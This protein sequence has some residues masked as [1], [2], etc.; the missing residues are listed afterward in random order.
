M[1][2]QTLLLYTVS[3]SHELT[4]LTDI[5]HSS[6]ELLLQVL[7]VFGDLLTLLQ[8]VLSGLL[9]RHCQDVGLLGAPFLLTGRSFV[10]SVHQGGHLYNRKGYQLVK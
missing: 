8:K 3:P 2:T 1:R 5:L 7:A 6:D 10:A 9:D 4:L